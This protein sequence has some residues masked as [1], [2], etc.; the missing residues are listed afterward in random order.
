MLEYDEHPAR[1]S[2]A[3]AQMINGNWNFMFVE[4]DVPGS[5]RFMAAEH[6]FYQAQRLHSGVSSG[7]QPVVNAKTSSS[8]K[9]N[10]SSCSFKRHC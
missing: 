4:I 10:K 6:L 7:F 2:E 5:R 8:K 3:M 9:S 1:T